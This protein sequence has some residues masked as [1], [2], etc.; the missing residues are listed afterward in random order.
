LAVATLAACGGGS[1][2]A[3]PAPTPSS[4]TIAGTAAQGAALPG[5]AVTIKCA[6]GAGAVTTGADGKYTLTIA[7]A[8]LPCALKV[9]GVNGA[10]FHSLLTGT[11]TSGSFTA[12]LSP[13]TELLVAKAAGVTPSAFFTNFAAG[14]AP[15][16][17]AVTQAIDALK[18]LAGGLIDLTGVHPI[19]DALVASNG[20]NAGNALDQKIDK[21][22]AALNNAQTT[23]DAVVAAV[24]SNPNVPDPI[25]T[26]LSPVATTCTALR[27]GKYRMINPYETDLAWK[28]H[29]IDVDAVALTAKTFEGEV[30]SIVANGNCQFTIDAVDET[31]TVMVS[32]A[33]V[34][35][36]YTQSKSG[37]TRNAAVGLPEQALPVSELAG[38]WNTIDW[39]PHSGSVIAGYVGTAD[40]VT[41]DSTGQITA[42]SSCLGLSCVANSAPFPK[43]SVA[44]SG[45]GFDLIESGTKVARVFLFKALSG[46]AVFVVVTDDGGFIIGSRQEAIATLPAVGTVTNYREF[47]LNGNGSLTTLLDQTNTVTAVDANAKTVTRLRTSDS[48][49]DT[50]SYDKPRAGLRYRA[51]NS[52]TVNGVASNC[53]E[54]V[55]MPLQGMGITLSVSVGTT[56]TNALLSASVNKPN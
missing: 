3:A 5:A 43:V 4:I 48:R 11:A 36:V 56:P 19:S 52:C 16:T 13:L 29:V 24:V 35:V 2:S 20:G 42:S 28:Y 22:M 15:S 55:Q 47:T 30:L 45:G 41:L 6:T 14:T 54:L 40:E 33:G 32:P 49:V 17:A 44:A 39:D 51:P 7:G 50:I 25:K 10:T 1:D 18:V 37:P 38:S 21:L 9:V 34:L 12:N 46:K 8:T 27:S 53:A 31:T 26:I 23:L